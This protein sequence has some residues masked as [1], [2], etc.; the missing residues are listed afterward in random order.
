MRAFFADGV[1]KLRVPQ[2]VEALPVL[3][4]LSLVLFFCGLI[5]FLFNIEHAVFGSV[6][7]WIAVFFM[8]YGCITVLPVFRHDSPYSTPL[9]RTAWFLYTSLSYLIL[10]FLAFI[11]PRSVI[12][13]ETRRRFRI[14]RDLYRVSIL[15]GVEEAAE[16]TASNRSSQID[17]RVLDWTISALGE[18]DTLEQFFDAIPGFFNSKIVRGLEEHFSFD[19]YTSFWWALDRFSR[20]TLSSNSV[21]ELAKSR[22][23]DVCMNVIK[24]IFS[25]NRTS[26]PVIRFISN[27]Y[28]RSNQVTPSIEI[29]HALARWCDDND[30]RIALGARAGVSSILASV[31]EH[32][33]RWVALAVRHL[34]LPEWLLQD[35]IA[36]G[37]DSVSLAILI[38]FVRQIRSD[39]RIWLGDTS[40]L[41]Q[42]DILNTLP[43]L[44]H[45]FCALWNQI[46]REA[47]REE[48]GSDPVK[49]VKELRRLYIPLHQGTCAA[50]TAF[51]A[52]TRG[53]EKVLEYPSSYP[54]C[55][56]A[57]HCT[58]SVTQSHHSTSVSASALPPT[59]SPD[60]PNAPT[61]FDTQSTTGRIA[62]PGEPEEPNVIPG[63]PSPDGPSPTS[64][65]QAQNITPLDYLRLHVRTSEVAVSSRAPPDSPLVLLQ[66]G[67]I[68]PNTTPPTGPP[69]PSVSVANSGEA[70]DGLQFINLG[71]NVAS[72]S[73]VQ[74]QQERTTSWAA[75]DVDG[76]V[77]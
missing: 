65:L 61:V 2:A 56:I 50:P 33:D 26:F 76:T 77:G 20:R 70:S 35:Y 49:I 4:H 45:E 14:L 37:Q 73:A 59:N 64:G 5:V 57:D 46:V 54:L 1:D 10:K 13:F 63:H 42:L 27:F 15:G 7:L 25:P 8:V 18:D 38:H 39:N 32:D 19:L 47:A 68:L 58:Q 48:A 23:I 3:L 72:Y 75:P 41:S 60:A 51:S 74:Q 11:S 29:G 24:V 53:V 34:E 17:I 43:G 36:H 69:L 22:R 30:E 9:S 67:V 52:S 71:L 31:A 21:M 44:Q 16:K 62:G 40:L 66:P 55:N 12:N 6:T 28:D